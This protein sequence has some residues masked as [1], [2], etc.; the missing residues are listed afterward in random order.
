MPL[1]DRF[2]EALLLACRWHGEQRRKISRTP[3]V[4]HLL[5]VT[6]IVLESGGTE[7]EAIAALL[8]DAIEDQGGAAAR[9]TI[10]EQFGPAVARIVDECS[11]TDQSPKPPWR[12]RKEAFLARLADVSPSARLVIAADK[13]DNVRGLVDAY[14]EQGDDIWRHFGG[15]RDGTL[16]YHRA[17]T[18]ALRAVSPGPLVERLHRA[19]VQLESL[20]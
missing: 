4:A 5:R 18:D 16:W 6:G 8:H 20:A 12:A 14:H 3:Y 17:V 15:G 13:L 10:E 1:T 11:D 2:T 19:M 7:D 9:Q